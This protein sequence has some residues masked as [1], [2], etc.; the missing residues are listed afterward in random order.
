[1]KYPAFHLCHLKLEGLSKY[2]N[3]TIINIQVVQE[4]ER[5]VLFVSVADGRHPATESQSAE[6]RRRSDWL[7]IRSVSLQRTEVPLVVSVSYMRDGYMCR[8]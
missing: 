5:A 8:K 3:S 6:V 1:M 7:L 4:Y 2:F